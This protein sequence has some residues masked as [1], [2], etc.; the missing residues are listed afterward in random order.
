MSGMMEMT[1]KG[2]I[3]SSVA[4]AA[5][6]LL[7]AEDSPRLAATKKWFKEAQFGMMAH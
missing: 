3:G 4:L 7:G 2:F 5:T 6:G 1:R